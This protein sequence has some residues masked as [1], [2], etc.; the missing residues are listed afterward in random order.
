VHNRW[1]DH[2]MLLL[3]LVLVGELALCVGESNSNK[4]CALRLSNT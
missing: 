1:F 3:R 2:E 4:S